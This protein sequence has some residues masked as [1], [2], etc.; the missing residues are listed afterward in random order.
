M[1]FEE[2]KE[3]QSLISN[4]FT[5]D[6]LKMLYYHACRVDI[7]DNNDKA[8]LVTEIIGPEFQEIGTGTNRVVY[9]YSPN[10]DR[11]FRGGAG[12][13]YEFALDRRGFLDSWSEFKR[14]QEI[15]E[16]AVKVY[17]TNMLI[18][19]QEYLT[20][21][22]EEEFKLNEP[23]IKEIL[24]RL[25]KDYIFEDIGYSM[26]NFENWGYRENGDIACL[27][28]GYVYPIR[29][30]EHVLSCPRC[31]GELK[32]NS[33][34]TGFVCQNGG[35]RRKYSFLEIRSRMD[36]SME[37]IEDKMIFNIMNADIP[38]FDRLTES[39]F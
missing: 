16:V 13:V 27:D 35:C 32:Y 3:R 29:G 4:I 6:D 2:T 30:N 34:Y 5:K 9:T 19:V 18:S 10:D 31:R 39:Q 26:K 28:L 11:E 23:Q 7:A 12:L 14:S 25:S 22:D 20:L 21:M 33:N 37:N 1:F 15:S 8:E 24:E 36:L 17:E 38:D